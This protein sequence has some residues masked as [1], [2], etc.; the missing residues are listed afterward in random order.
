MTAL[1]G[2]ASSILSACS[3]SH[4]SSSSGRPASARSGSSDP[5]DAAEDHP[6]AVDD[7]ASSD[8]SIEQDHTETTKTEV[9]I[10]GETE[11]DISL[12]ES[13]TSLCSSSTVREKSF[14]VTFAPD[15]ET[16]AWGKDGNLSPS[17][18]IRAEQSAYKDFEDPEIGLLCGIDISMAG[19]GYADDEVVLTFNQYVLAT[20][21]NSYE[22]YQIRGME[23]VD[24]LIKYDR[25]KV[26]GGTWDAARISGCA[27]GVVCD[28]KN[29]NQQSNGMQGGTFTVNTSDQF[30][31]KLPRELLTKQKHT[32]GLHLTGNRSSTDCTHTGFSFNVKA[33]FYPE[34]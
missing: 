5:E 9:D 1:T 7:D 27:P 10:A 20:S 3:E 22:W 26:I 16:C 4:F 19:S 6:S 32:L 2:F 18:Q 21:W 31:K 23:I 14:V 30:V 8:I 24:G 29:F 12:D 15:T 13:V 34:P 28:F 33:R 11:P 17:K 25:L